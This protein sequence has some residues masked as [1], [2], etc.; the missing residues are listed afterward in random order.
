M[1]TTVDLP[2]DL[3]VEIKSVYKTKV[4]KKALVLACEQMIQ[5]AKIE[6]LR[7]LR[8]TM[9]LNVDL[10]TARHGRNY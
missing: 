1:R 4:L 7:S 5:K 9:N 8:G 3:V 6:K 10:E 2:N